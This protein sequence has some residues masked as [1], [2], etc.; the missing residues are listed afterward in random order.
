MALFLRKRDLWICESVRSDGVIVA[1]KLTTLTFY[2]HFQVLE[3]VLVLSD[4]IFSESYGIH[5]EKGG[6]IS[7]IDSPGRC[8]QYYFPFV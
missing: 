8:K 7:R 5:W 6:W 2:T 3:P 1:W 4:K